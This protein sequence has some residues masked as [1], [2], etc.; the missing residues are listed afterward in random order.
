MV[1]W[2]KA[3]HRRRASCATRD[4]GF[5]SSLP[6][7]AATGRPKGR[8]TIGRASAGLGE[9]LAG[10]DVLVPSHTSD[11]C[12]RPGAVHAATV[13]RCTVFPPPHWYGWLPGWMRA[14]LR[15]S[16]AWLGCDSEDARL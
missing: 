14:V 2:F 15:S 5:E 3:W 8:H 13:A 7:P 4:S 10:R 6:Q 11:F 9:R 1:Q 12:G 16:A